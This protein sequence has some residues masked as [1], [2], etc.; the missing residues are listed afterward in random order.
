MIDFLF[1]K[2]KAKI[3]FMIFINQ[4]R[5]IERSSGNLLGFHSYI[6]AADMTITMFKH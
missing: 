4:Y 3:K 2:W 5:C 1:L 6:S